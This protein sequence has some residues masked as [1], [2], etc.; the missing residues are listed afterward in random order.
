MVVVVVVLVLV[1]MVLQL[2]V[3]VILG[4]EKLVSGLGAIL[5]LIEMCLVT[6]NISSV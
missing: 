3:S 5:L 6:G 2:S 4:G 1:L